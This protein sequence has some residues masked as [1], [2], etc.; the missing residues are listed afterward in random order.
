MS[1]V[2]HGRSLLNEIVEALAAASAVMI[3][4]VADTAATTSVKICVI[5]G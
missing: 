3:G 2:G 4:T 1:V 5:C